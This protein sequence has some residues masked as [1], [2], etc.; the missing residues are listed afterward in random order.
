MDMGI[1]RNGPAI[2]VPLDQVD[3]VDQRFESRDPETPQTEETA[4][5]AGL[6]LRMERIDCPMCSLFVD[7]PIVDD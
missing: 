5:G 3:Q 4:D 6:A 7:D 2:A 1:D